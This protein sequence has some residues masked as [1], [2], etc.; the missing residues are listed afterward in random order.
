MTGSHGC[1]SSGTD[2]MRWGGTRVW[3]GPPVPDP[4]PALTVEPDSTRG[5]MSMNRK[6]LSAALIAATLALTT[7]AH[8]EALR[9]RRSVTELTAN[10]RATFMA[11]LTK[12]KHTPAPY[13]N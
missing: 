12:L 6:I 5:Q 8:A 2:P 11:A 4:P 13:A 10:E 9:V 3:G 1:A 7:Q